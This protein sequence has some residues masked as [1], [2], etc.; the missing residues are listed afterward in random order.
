MRRIAGTLSM[1]MVFLS[2]S[3]VALAD[4]PTA[5][6][7]ALPAQS[8][9]DSLRAVGSQAR[10]NIV[11]NPGLVRGHTAPALNADLTTAQALSRLLA[12]TGFVY[13]FV[14]DSTIVV[15]SGRRTMHLDPPSSTGAQ[16]P[17]AHQTSDDAGPA[18]GSLQ[19]VVVTG[20]LIPTNPDAVAVPV[21]TIEASALTATGESSDML[22]TLEKT[23][24]AFA[25][26]SNA[27]TSNAQN[28]NQFTAGGSQIELRNLP[29]LVLVNGQR[30]ALDAVA[31]LTGS[32]D[33][34]DVSQ[35]PAA[36]LQRV[37]VLTDGAS[38]LYGSDA[39]GGVVNFILKHNYHGVTI[40][41]HYG[42]ADGYRDRSA[43]ITL[44]GDAGPINIT[45]TLSYAKTSPLW[46]DSRAF[47]SPK[48]GVTP[49]TA[50][51]GVVDGGNYVLAPGLL[52]PP[53]PTGS[54]ATASSYSQLPG[55]YDA[56]TAAQLSDAF[57]YS[58]YVMLLQQEEHKNFV[59]DITSK[60]LFG[61][62]TEAFGEILVSQNRVRSTAW[63][64][65]GQPFSNAVVSVP[66][67][68]P[69]DPLTTATTA[70]FADIN[71]PKGV[72][73]TTD[74]YQFSMGLKG[75]LTHSWTWQTS[76][77]YS[78]SKLTE[79]DTNLIYKPNLA[80]AI[81]GGYN[82]SGVATA[83]GA[84]S[85][86]YGDLSSSNPMILVPALNPFAVTGNPSATLAA[87]FGTEVLHGAS[88]LYSWDAHAVGNVFKLPAGPFSL[89]F[90]VSWRREEVS[91]HAD[92]NGR[93]TDP[94]T[95]LTSGNDQNWIGGVYTDPF[96]H[97]RDDS[98]VYAETRIPVFSSRMGIPGLN[99]LEFTAA[100]RFEHYSDAGSS[101][102]PKFGF[103][104]APLNNQF[105]INGTYTKSFVAPPMFQAYGPYDTRQVTG[106]IPG[107]VFGIAAL[108]HG[109]LTFNGE[110]GNNPALKP[111]VAVARSIGFVFRPKYINGLLLTADFSSI[112]LYGFAGGIGFNNIFN[113]V[114][115]LGAAS[116]FFGN[117]GQGNFVNF[118]GTDPF[119]TPGA[120][121]AYL[122]ANPANI[123]NIYVEDRF[124]NLAVLRERSWTLAG[125]Y[126]LPWRRYGTWTL[127]SNAMVFDSYEFSDGLGDPTI[128]Y[129]G[130]A[131][132]LGVFAGTLPK[133][134]LYSTLEWSY[135]RLDISL[136]NTYISSVTDAGPGGTG[137]HFVAVP[138]YSA[139]DLR[140]AYTWPFGAEGSGRKL[141]LAIGVNDLNDATPPY[142]PNAFSNAFLTTDIGTYSPVER[143][144][145]GDLTVSF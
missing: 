113:S 47:S 112:N 100:G 81:D 61:G 68:S 133:Y 121:R 118:G 95:G 122:A 19:Q 84:Y 124:T 51:P 65:A 14:N 82:G 128:Q 93:N 109:S 85:K 117:L 46:A 22:A 76:V 83:D 33:F 16:A 98:A 107:N 54:A 72:Y 90:G 88:R 136:S 145:Y 130:N 87:L 91:G 71:R 5:M 104:W 7:F 8:L 137:P 29:T 48:Y 138:H 106:V 99:Q 26:R 101:T 59:A 15:S 105:A 94:A 21:T 75:H 2:L 55:V 123:Q 32:K 141:V 10:I 129:A 80:L 23:M 116:P 77:D 66:A 50:L 45:A 134:R 119:A 102:T 25:G 63:Q 35:I 135:R 143:L 38:S 57:D 115:R 20:T 142:F 6:H 74:G 44:G 97:G 132:N 62:S 52:Y 126:I 30:L 110:D 42:A 73:D 108:Q 114:N 12:G 79:L 96:S 58:K 64:T 53:V 125:L 78:E 92:P 4:A 49:G 60:P 111:A 131:S 37:D 1:L 28:H 11:F 103:R 139:F 17:A 127:S 120:L 40:G 24:P 18:Q 89:A 69:Y 43:F 36:A 13:E 31:G 41:T 39:I 86:V 34:V 9:A 67:G 140:G 144:V 27:G 3:G 70:T 56:T